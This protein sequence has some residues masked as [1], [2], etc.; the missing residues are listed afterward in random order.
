MN[1]ISTAQLENLGQLRLPFVEELGGVAVAATAV[2]AAAATLVVAKIRTT[3]TSISVRLQHFL[4]T[5]SGDA[6]EGMDES[7]VM[8]V[9]AEAADEHDA[10]AALEG[11]GFEVRGEFA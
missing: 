4:M 7:V 2:A 5:L 3:L 1:R 10:V 9:I 6:M 11:M 8:G